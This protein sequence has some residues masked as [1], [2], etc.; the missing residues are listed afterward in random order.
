V[1][2]AYRSN[3]IRSARAFANNVRLI[4]GNDSCRHMRHE[5]RQQQRYSDALLFEVCLNI[6][7]T[8]ICT[9]MKYASLPSASRSGLRLNWLMNR[10][11][12]C[13]EVTVVEEVVHWCIMSVILHM[14]QRTGSTQLLFDVHTMCSN[15]DAHTVCS[16]KASLRRVD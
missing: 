9:P 4:H 7:S 15:D 13:S 12:S 11:P 3:S 14:H 1:C 8:A 5:K 16:V 2:S 10:V 6:P